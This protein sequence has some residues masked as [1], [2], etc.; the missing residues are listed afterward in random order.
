MIQP[1]K[2]GDPIQG[3]YVDRV[4]ITQW[5]SSSVSRTFDCIEYEC[6]YR[7]AGKWYI[8]LQCDG[9]NGGVTS[10]ALSDVH[11]GNVEAFAEERKAKRQK[12]F[13]K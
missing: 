13:G 12:T 9:P 5:G 10:Q 2:V 4:I 3:C 7:V 11:D 8:S 1:I 6:L